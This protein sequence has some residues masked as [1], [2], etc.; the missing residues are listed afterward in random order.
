MQNKGKRKETKKEHKTLT[1]E[2]KRK[3]SKQAREKIILV[4][5]QFAEGSIT[6][7]QS[8]IEER[9]PSRNANCRLF[10]SGSRNR[11]GE[12]RFSGEKGKEED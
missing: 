9:T 6:D 1:L 7:A 4:I 3:I 5:I 2:S 8:Q 12:A 11:R 10:E